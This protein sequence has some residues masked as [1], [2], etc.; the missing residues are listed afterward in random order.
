MLSR[1]YLWI[2]GLAYAGLGLFCLFRPL[3]AAESVGFDLVTRSAR[4]EFATFYGGGMLAL[5]A[6]FLIGGTAKRWT[7]AVCL[8]SL[9]F[10]LLLAFVRGFW[11]L[12]L[13]PDQGSTIFYLIV[14]I[15]LAAGAA[16]VL[17]PFWKRI[18]A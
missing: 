16:V 12:A 18:L 2:V 3:R 5:A 11:A 10:H 7:E 1:G 15:V 6:V 13:H 17:R 14:E 8:F 9:G 4:I